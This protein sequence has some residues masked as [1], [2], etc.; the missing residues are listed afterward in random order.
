VTPKAIIALKQSGVDERVVSAMLERA[1]LGEVQPQSSSKPETGSARVLVAGVGPAP[2]LQTALDEL[3]DFFRRA[4][5][6]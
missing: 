5:I 2:H 1:R 3:T 4:N 6:G